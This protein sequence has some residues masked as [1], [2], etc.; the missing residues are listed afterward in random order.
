VSPSISFKKSSLLTVLSK[1]LTEAPEKQLF[2]RV[3]SSSLAKITNLLL[4]SRAKLTF[5][6][7][8]NPLKPFCA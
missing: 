6:V 7:F 5:V 2:A 1:K 8:L 3:L 4:N